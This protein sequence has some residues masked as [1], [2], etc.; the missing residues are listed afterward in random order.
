M[1]VPDR[2]LHCA[3]CHSLRLGEIE[4]LVHGLVPG[5]LLGVDVQRRVGGHAAGIGIAA[6]A[7]AG[8]HDLTGAGGIDARGL[9]GCVVLVPHRHAFRVISIAGRVGVGA[10]TRHRRRR[11]A[12]RPLPPAAPEPRRGRRVVLASI[13]TIVPA[14]GSG[15]RS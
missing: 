1:G 10:G 9:A 8:I 5:L 3:G 13:F 12:D 2:L 6:V 15:R 7:R 14:S 11:P 4:G